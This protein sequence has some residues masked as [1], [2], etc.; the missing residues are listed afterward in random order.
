M[1][2]KYKG[3][4]GVEYEQQ[5]Q[6]A[7]QAYLHHDR[8]IDE[9]MI[10]ALKLVTEQ[11][12]ITALLDGELIAVQFSQFQT[13]SAAASHRHRIWKKKI[14]GRHDTIIL[15]DTKTVELQSGHRLQG[16]ETF[17]HGSNWA[18]LLSVLEMRALKAGKK[19]RPPIGIYALKTPEEVRKH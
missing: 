6:I 1:R 3:P 12:R 16:Q 10:V 13:S 4:T 15:D 7:F 2:T 14:E 5:C 11:E 8:G 9:E 19:G 18:A 17:Y